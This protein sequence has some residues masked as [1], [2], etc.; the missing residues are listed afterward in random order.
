MK[1][2]KERFRQYLL[3]EGEPCGID[4]ISLEYRGDTRLI[5]VTYWNKETN[6]RMTLS[7][8]SRTVNPWSARNAFIMTEDFKRTWR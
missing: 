4:Y 8:L 1:W 5:V 7:Y 6:N 3:I 2:N